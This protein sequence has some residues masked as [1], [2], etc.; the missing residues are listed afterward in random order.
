MKKLI[1]QARRLSVHDDVPV[2]IQG[3]SG[4]GKELFARAI[5]QSSPRKDN[6]FIA[7]NCGAIPPELVESELFGYK[8]G[9]FTGASQDHDGYFLAADGGTLFLDEIGELPFPAQVKM[10]RTIQEGSVTRIGT[11]K[12]QKINVRII[13]ATNRNLIDEMAAGRFREDLFHRLAVGVL[14]LPPLRERHGDL[15]PLIDFILEGINKKFEG[16]PGWKQRNFLQ[17]REIFSISIPGP[18]T[19]ENFPIPFR[20]RQSGRRKKPSTLTTCVNL[21]SA[22]KQH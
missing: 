16:K 21:F 10:L 8:K 3:E 11:T 22:C 20:G 7:V 17:A 6:P 9:S 5:H 18:G 2:L 1:A 14:K 12:P 15:N 19:S 4:T 13:A